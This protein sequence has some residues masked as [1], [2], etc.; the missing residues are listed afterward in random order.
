MGGQVWGLEQ[1]QPAEDYR[2]EEKYTP[3]EDDA[4]PEY[5]QVFHGYKVPWYRWYS[6][7]RP[8]VEDQL[9]GHIP[10][11]KAVADYLAGK[12]PGESRALRGRSEENSASKKAK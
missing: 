5:V 10:A 6:A 8:D 9:T 12:K 2:T 4:G 7:L 1:R 11:C 3:W